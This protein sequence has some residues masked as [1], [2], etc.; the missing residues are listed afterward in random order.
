[1]ILTNS[2]AFLVDRLDRDL[3]VSGGL[4]QKWEAHVHWIT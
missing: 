4:Q 1:M 3:F 2:S